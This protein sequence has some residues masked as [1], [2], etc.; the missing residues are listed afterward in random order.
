MGTVLSVLHLSCRFP[1]AESIFFFCF[2]FWIFFIF[3]ARASDQ[4]NINRRSSCDNSLEGTKKSSQ[5]ENIKTKF[6]NKDSKMKVTIVCSVLALFLALWTEA[7]DSDSRTCSGVDW[8]GL[9]QNGKLVGCGR[10][11]KCWRQC[12]HGTPTMCIPVWRRLSYIRKLRLSKEKILERYAI[13]CK[14]DQDCFNKQA[15]RREC[16]DAR[17][18]CNLY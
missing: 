6:R 17:A 8:K 4:E 13:D 16:L 1:D 3:K 11:D 9:C 10:N 12:T 7:A 14:N 15:G 2:F 18:Y 5:A